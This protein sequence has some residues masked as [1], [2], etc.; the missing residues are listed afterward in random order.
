MSNSNII[1]G[2]IE[3]KKAKDLFEDVV[4]QSGDGT[5]LISNVI[6]RIEQTKNVFTTSSL[7]PDVVIE[8][9]RKEWAADS[10][11]VD[12]ITEKIALL[13]PEQREAIENV[14]DKVLEGESLEIEYHENKDNG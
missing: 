9:I 12:A 2:I 7:F 4:R 13:S 14:I 6:K 11:T 1:N 3:L 10:F 8:G 5:K